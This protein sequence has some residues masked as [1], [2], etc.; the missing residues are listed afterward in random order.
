VDVVI[1]NCVINLVQDKGQAF[2]EAYR[3]LKPGGRLSISDIVTDRP[4]NPALRANPQ[5]W[6]PASPALFRKSNILPWSPR[7]VLTISRLYAEGLA[8]GERVSTA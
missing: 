5:S 2:R 7:Q 4:F 8:A 3:V 6:S 1:S